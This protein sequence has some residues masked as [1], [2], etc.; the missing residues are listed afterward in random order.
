MS[1]MS[2]KDGGLTEEAGR[3]ILKE[4]LKKKISGEIVLSDNP[5]K[6]IKKWRG[7]FE[8]S[9]RRLADEIDVMPSVVSDYE[10]GRRSSPGIKMIE[11]IVTGLVN[12][13]EE[14]G[15]EVI[16]KFS[17][18]S[19]TDIV[20]DTVLDVK[21]FS[22]GVDI[23]E[24]VDSCEAELVVNKDMAKKQIYGYSLIDSLKAIVELSPS[25]LVRLYGLTTE[26][27]LIFTKVSTGRSPMVAIKV[28]NLKPGLVV[29][30]GNVGEVDELAKRVAKAEGVPLAVSRTEDIDQLRR[31]LAEDFK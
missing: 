14:K 7:I 21:E 19:P 15:G 6:T 1:G 18:F 26:R 10:L 2:N 30:H 13:D 11:K 12:V 25:E 27:A 23:D 4:R 22:R 16:R 24:F 8:I 20:S 9:Q 17:E 29:F 5:G 3:D 28:T 31:N